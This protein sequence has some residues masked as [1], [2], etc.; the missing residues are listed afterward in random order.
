MALALLQAL[1]VIRPG[2]SGPLPDTLPQMLVV[3]VTLAWLA[4]LAD[5]VREWATRIGG[6]PPGTIVLW[7]AGGLGWR[8]S[9]GPWTSRLAIALAPAVASVCVSVTLGTALLL[10]TGR[11]DVALPGPWTVAGLDPIAGDRMW[12]TIWL[13]QWTNMAMLAASAIPAHPFVG[14]RIIEASLEPWLGRDGALRASLVLG[15][16]V[17]SILAIAG[18]AFGSLLTVICGIVAVAVGM[19][20]GRLLGMRPGMSGLGLWTMIAADASSTSRERARIREERQSR[21]DDAALDGILAKV[22]RD[23]IDSLTRDERRVLARSTARR[24]SGQRS[25][26]RGGDRPPGRDAG[27]PDAG[28]DDPAAS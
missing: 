4:L 16:V 17:G 22:A 9:P 8:E 18:L 3:L 13:V 11:W 21:D 15:I 2:P 20:G 24:R 23:G 12:A 6:G 19:S 25:G 28:G 26:D 5:A 14:A 7:P 27:D 10:R 1:R